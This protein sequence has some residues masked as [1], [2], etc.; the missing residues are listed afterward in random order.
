MALTPDRE[1]KTRQRGSKERNGESDSRGG[2]VRPIMPV[3]ESVFSVNQ[4]S[5]S[6]PDTEPKGSEEAERNR[7]PEEW[8]ASRSVISFLTVSSK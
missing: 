5:G 4:L 3:C 6:V 7:E 2:A 1:I 8:T